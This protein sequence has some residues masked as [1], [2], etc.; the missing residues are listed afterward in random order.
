MLVQALPRLPGLPAVLLPQDE[1]QARVE[2]AEDRGSLGGALQEAQQRHGEQDHAAAEET[3]RA[4]GS[5]APSSL[6]H[7]LGFG[8]SCFIIRPSPPEQRKPLG[9]REA[10]RSG[11]HLHNR[12]RADAWRAEPAARGGGGRQEQRPPSDVA[13]G[14]AGEAEEGAEFHTEGE[15]DHRGLGAKLQER[16]GE[17]KKRSTAVPVVQVLR[18][19][20]CLSRLF[21]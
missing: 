1:G 15:E 4:G 10:S 2:E 19:V 9:Q 12:E 5:F 11:E 20:T 18:G 17:S 7:P 21:S 3:R 16:N 13:A 6:F 14:G 8:L